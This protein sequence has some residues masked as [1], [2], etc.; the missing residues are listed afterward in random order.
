MWCGYKTSNEETPRRVTTV[1]HLPSLWRKLSSRVSTG[2]YLHKQESSIPIALRLC[3]HSHLSLWFLATPIL[4]SHCCFN[5]QSPNEGISDII[6]YVC[7]LPMVRRSLVMYFVCFKYMFIIAAFKG[8]GVCCC[9][10]CCFCYAFK[11][12]PDLCFK[13]FSQQNVSYCWI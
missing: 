4:I 11:P 3:P 13:Y 10:C 8:F 1:V 12:T 5:L 2:F 7:L 6:L 9:C